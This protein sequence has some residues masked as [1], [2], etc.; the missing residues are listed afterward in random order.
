MLPATRPNAPS[1]SLLLRHRHRSASLLLCSPNLL[2]L[3]CKN[4]D[5]LPELEPYDSIFLTRSAPST[6]SPKTTCLPSSHEVTTV[7][8][9]NWEPLVLGP[10]LAIDNRLGRSWR[11]LKFSS[12]NLLP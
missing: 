2:C 4:Y 3:F 7:V 11:N 1:H 12:A 8:T 9:K 10:A 6:T 5:L